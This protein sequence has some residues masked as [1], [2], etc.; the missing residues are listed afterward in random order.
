MERSLY[1]IEILIIKI[2]PFILAICGFIRTI[3]GIFGII[4]PILAYISALS[5]LPWVFLLTSSFVFKFCIWH[6]LPLYYIGVNECVNLIDCYWLFNF[7]D[8]TMLITNSLI[9]GA[10][11]ITCGILKYYN[12]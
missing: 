1:K 10:F 3:L 5:F 6:R 2:L 4:S 11:S 8:L 9:F 12:R 7:S